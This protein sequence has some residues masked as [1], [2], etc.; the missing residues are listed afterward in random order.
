MCKA[1]FEVVSDNDTFL[2]IVDLDQGKTVTNDASAVIQSLD[3]MTRDGLR[4][5]RVYYRDTC[6]RFDELEHS[7]DR[8]TRILPCKDSQQRFL[9]SFVPSRLQ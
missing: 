9:K 6:G 2:L 4:N 3:R 8:F 7:Q 1:K 5:R